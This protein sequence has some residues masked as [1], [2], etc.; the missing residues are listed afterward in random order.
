MAPAPM[1]STLSEA[2]DSII[3][4]SFLFQQQPGNPFLR[5]VLDFF[6]NSDRRRQSPP[7]DVM[8]LILTFPTPHFIDMLCS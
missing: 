2:Y 4:M 3:A 5:A 8:E 1:M 7:P 6:S